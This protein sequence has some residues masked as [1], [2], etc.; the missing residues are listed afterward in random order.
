MEVFLKYICFIYDVFGK[1]LD[2][3]FFFN[4]FDM[5]KTHDLFYNLNDLNIQII[6]NLITINMYFSINIILLF[7]IIFCLFKN[8][9][10]F[11]LKFYVINDFFNSQKY[12]ILYKDWN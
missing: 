11:S 2:N 8:M 6:I 1:S 5:L 12:S 4:V 9:F 3:K 7:Y 10:D